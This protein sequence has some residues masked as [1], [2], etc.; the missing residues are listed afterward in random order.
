MKAAIGSVAAN[1][2]NASESGPEDSLQ[3]EQCFSRLFPK[4]VTR[5][6]RWEIRIDKPKPQL[7]LFLIT[8]F[9]LSL[10]AEHLQ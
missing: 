5:D 7:V 2:S 3:I 8:A 4:V 1:N 10:A 6:S 9:R